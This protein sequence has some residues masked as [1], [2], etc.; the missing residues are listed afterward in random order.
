MAG[1]S[2]Q[3]RMLIQELAKAGFS[4]RQIAERLDKRPATVRKWRRRGQRA[5]SGALVVPMG[6]PKRGS[7][8]SFPAGLVSEIERMRK[9]HPGWG[10]KT[11]LAELRR[12][13]AYAGQALPE[14]SSIA[15]WLKQSGQAKAYEKH[16]DLPTAPALL[17]KT[18]H[19]EWEM[20][21]RGQEKIPRVGVIGL[22]Q[23][24]DVYSKVKLLSYP[25][26]LGEQRADHHPTTQDYQMALRLAF[27][28]WGLPER[29]A[30]DHDSVYF[31]N[32]SKSPFPTRFHL[33]LVS[34]GIRLTFGRFARPT[35][36]AMTERSH[37]TWAHQVLEGQ[38]FRNYPA[39][40]LALQDRL[41]FLNNHLPCATLDERPPLVAHPEAKL[42]RRPY[43][44]EAEE[45][46]LDLR[47]MD[48][49]L[50]QGKWYRKASNVGE[51]S[52]GGQGYCLGHAWQRA[53]V[54]VTFDP[55]D[56]V[57]VCQAEGH[58]ELRKPLLGLAAE[59]LMGDLDQILA[60]PF[61]QLALP[62][63]PDDWKQLFLVTTLRGTTLCNC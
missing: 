19:E 45:Q 53:E 32:K 11:L 42:L 49:F 18:C 17:A 58:P 21:A 54:T 1:I 33:G 4:D 10:P 14:K 29:L 35:D 27:T 52:L 44:P 7:L 20:D 48:A 41:D 30:V 9:Q 8:S 15:R 3:E 43:R 2:L 40:F 28:H 22:I 25:C 50:A 57:L 38:T 51:I 59:D 34:L 56:R 60:L 26:L 39:L 36:Q 61:F 12:K 6:R 46:L 5:G 24:N 47:R 16:Q 37:Q 13:P 55:A 62:F 31:D 63:S 23:I